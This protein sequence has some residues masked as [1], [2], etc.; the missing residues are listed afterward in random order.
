M[1][2]N[3]VIGEVIYDKGKYIYNKVVE[4]EKQGKNCII[5]VPSQARMSSE[6]EYILKT[7]KKGM[8]NTDITTISRYISKMLD[9]KLESKEYIT[10]DVKRIYIKQII[11]E[12]K[13]E[14]SMF[15]KVID[16]P[17]FVDLVISYIDSIKKENIDIAKLEEIEISNSMTKL[18]LK[19]IVEICSIV[20]DKI[21]EKYVD[22]LD[23]LDVFNKYI[24]ERKEEF[25]NK[26]IFFHGY[27]NF[28]KKELDII[29]TFLSIGLNVTVTLTMPYDLT[30][31]NECKDNIFEIAH[32]TY[33][34]L[35]NISS[36]V[37]TKF[38]VVKD[39]DKQNIP[40]DIEYLTENIFGNSYE[41]YAKK[42]NNV[43]LKLEKNQNTEIENIA[44]EIVGKIREDNTL[45]FKDFAIYTNNFDEYE[46]CIKRIFKEYEIAYS[47]DDTSEVEFSNLAIYIFT[48]LK[49]AEEGLDVN[50]LILLLKTNLYDIS[51]EDLNYLENYILEFGIKGYTLNR[52]FK[53]NNK[54]GAL[55]S[56]VYDLER[57]NNIREKIVGSVNEFTN[58]IKEKSDVK[59]KIEVIYNHIIENNIIKK[60]ALEI[61]QTV[62][63]SVKQADLKKQVINSI[64]EIFDNIEMLDENKNMELSTFI[65][66]FEFGMKDRKIKTIPMTI[67]QVEIC[68]IN[69]S[70]ILPKKYVYMIGAYE[71]GLP[72]LSNEDVMFSDKEL[73]E[74]KD[75]NIELKQNS[76]TRSNMAL[77]NVYTTIAN[78]ENKLTVTM[79]VS[80]ITG[81]PLRPSILINEIK[82]I[83]NVS[84]EG[85]ISNDENIIFK[86][87]K[88]TSR[89]MFKNL[90]S[91]IVELDSVDEKDLEYL[92]NLYNHT[93]NIHQLC[94]HFYM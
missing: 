94:H 37:K 44:Q 43:T 47:F 29:K 76:L 77:F 15:S 22:S 3:C 2:L 58:S 38:N 70:R 9:N 32:K 90:L 34:D 92:Y 10:D 14:Q 6:E 33:L 62:D 48:L 59:G 61:S 12:N 19:E 8:L 57:L 24:I 30:Y 64:Y 11:N 40:E 25:Q 87:D 36:E 79:P 4:L 72:S 13:L 83:L 21:S 5:F 81:E 74:L 45:R 31:L 23:M 69:K 50:K 42:S 41:E 17:S 89:V 39:L 51:N 68:D 86:S 84:L 91:S 54:E 71:N 35:V 26:E 1:S 7:N 46:F 16:K 82:R 52:E 80:K 78:A 60:Y 93:I 27:N 85:N 18:K 20:N 63:S 88:M 65:E 56:I 67:D 66:L 28:S 73:D 53:K 49:I 75:K 55:G